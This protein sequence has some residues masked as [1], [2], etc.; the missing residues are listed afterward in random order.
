[1]F[2]LFIVLIKDNG[3]VLINVIHVFG[4]FA[5][6]WGLI[7]NSKRLSFSCIAL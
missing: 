4:S 2:S 5:C 3:V 7:D 6:S 1:M